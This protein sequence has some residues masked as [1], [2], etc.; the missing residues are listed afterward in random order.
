MIANTQSSPQSQNKSGSP[1]SGGP[2]FLTIGKLQRTH[3]VKG[4]IVM[5]IL[6][7]F[8]ERISSGNTVYIGQKHM[9]YTIASI[10]PTSD[11]LLVSFNGFTDCDQVSILRNQYIYIKTED[12]NLL[13]EGEFYHHE[14]IGMQVFDESGTNIGSIKE[15]LVTGANDVYVITGQ[16]EEEI[17]LPAIRSAVISIERQS[18]KMVVKLPEWA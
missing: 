2:V 15:I 1:Q 6:T 9:E 16:A 11:K 10:R 8:P 14:I 12:A 17:L 7:D 3:G 13:P 5:D 4:E 18:R